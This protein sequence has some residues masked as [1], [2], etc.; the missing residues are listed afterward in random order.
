MSAELNLLFRKM[1]ATFLFGAIWGHGRKRR[2]LAAAWLSG[3]GVEIGA[4]HSPLSVPA[5]THVTYLD[6]MNNEDLL[7]QYPELS[8]KYLAPVD[9]IDD[10]EI[11][12]TI[13][14]ASQNFIIANH[15][16]EHCENPIGALESWLRVLKE[17][18]IAYI[19]VPDKRFTFDYKREATDWAHLYRDF[20]IGPEHSRGHHYRDWVKTIMGIAGGEV[21]AAYK[22]LEKMRYSIHFHAWSSKSLRIFFNCCGTELA[23][24]FS[25]CEFVRNGVEI[26]VILQK[27]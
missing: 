1:A 27:K 11:L 5:G 10:G 4:L 15:F 20:S 21:D 3:R 19:A 16:L 23:L 7:R 6:R 9:V 13:P 22:H 8:E 25:L 14:D 17:G 24:P 2:L 26:I 18:G 12:S